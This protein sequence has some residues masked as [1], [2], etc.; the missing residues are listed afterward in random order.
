MKAYKTII[1]LPRTLV[2][3]FCL[4]LL[5]GVSGTSALYAQNCDAF[6]E[7]EVAVLNPESFEKYNHVYEYELK[8]TFAAPELTDE[9]ALVTPLTVFYPVMEGTYPLVIISHGWHIS[10]KPNASLARYLA[11]QGYVTAILS[12]KEKDYPEEFIAAFES[13]YTLL[14][15]ANDNAES[16]LFRRMDMQKTAI[17]GHSMGGTAAL[18]FA[19]TTLDTGV[20]IALNPYNGASS[21]IERVGG[22]NEV[23]GTDLTTLRVPVLIITGSKDN[24]AYPE[25][26]FA[27]YE[28]CNTSAPAAFL[29]VKNGV[30]GSGLDSSGNIL[31]GWFD[32][33][34]YMRY[35]LLILGWLDLFLEQKISEASMPFLQPDAFEAIKDWFYS[36]NTKRYPAYTFRNFLC[37]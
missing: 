32:A 14:K 6:F 19:K 36:G 34:L 10:K 28:H 33:K 30:H 3:F 24:V 4:L 26:S 18:H 27:F 16:R 35:R 31:S 22:K 37:R 21:L 11:S 7:Y 13:A 2:I 20:V 17:I 9:D 8:H 23:L 12:A 25:K 5:S 15:T 1:F 29:A